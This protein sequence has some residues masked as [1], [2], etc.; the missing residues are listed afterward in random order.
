MDVGAGALA[1]LSRTQ[2]EKP[3]VDFGESDCGDSAD[4]DV[5]ERA[6]K[7]SKHT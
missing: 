7:D 1:L 3:D 4:D 6:E 2:E 5:D